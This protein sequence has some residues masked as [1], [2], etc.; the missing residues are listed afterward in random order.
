MGQILFQE[1]YDGSVVDEVFTVLN[2]DAI[3]T[4]KILA[5]K[6]GI[7][8]GISSGTN[9]FASLEMAK[10]LGSGKTVVTILPDTG[11]RYLSAGIYHD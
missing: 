7:L 4:T 6:Y 10:K 11:E 8:A 3:N 1:N 9:F 2:E 5:K